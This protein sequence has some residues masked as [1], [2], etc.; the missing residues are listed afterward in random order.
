M[1]AF[2]KKIGYNNIKIGSANMLVLVALLIML[3]L[4]GC[5]GG[6]TK[7]NAPSGSCVSLGYPGD[8]GS[9]TRLM[10]TPEV[11]IRGMGEEELKANII[12]Y[13][14][15]PADA[16]N[17]GKLA[18]LK[19]AL[20]EKKP[21]WSEPVKD[22]VL[23]CKVILG[24]TREQVLL[25]W[26]QPL[27]RTRIETGLGLQEKWFYKSLKYDRSCCFYGLSNISNWFV[28][29]C[30]G[31]V[32]RLFNKNNFCGLIGGSRTAY[33]GNL[34]KKELTFRNGILVTIREDD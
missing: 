12:N 28:D 2:K 4:A 11:G 23:D 17:D 31:P 20:F 16:C 7:M 14:R 18:E 10:L 33:V 25:S 30:I 9:R 21:E 5:A 6:S 24:I 1:D 3:E 32:S 29:W 34:F 15:L 22:A 19:L 13:T 8:P 26:G 27:K